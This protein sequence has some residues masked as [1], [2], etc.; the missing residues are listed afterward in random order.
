MMHRRASLAA[1]A[2]LLLLASTAH[3]QQCYQADQEVNVRK[4]S[5]LEELRTGFV[6]EHS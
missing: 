2:A 1:A 3:A 5:G 6:P 4:A